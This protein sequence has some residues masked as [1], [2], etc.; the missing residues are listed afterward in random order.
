MSIHF[1]DSEVQ[2]STGNFLTKSIQRDLNSGVSVIY[3][4]TIRG[5]QKHGISR[6]TPNLMVIES[7]DLAYLLT[8]VRD[9]LNTDWE[10]SIYIDHFEYTT[11][12][13]PDNP[14]SE[15]MVTAKYRSLLLVML[16]ILYVNTYITC[17]KL[18]DKPSTPR[19]K[20]SISD[21]NISDFT[22]EICQ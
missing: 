3:I 18:P 22:E 14:L 7:N 11:A 9:L 15:D 1:Y 10:G 5:F 21:Y 6:N 12:C 19:N 16:N 4:D 2:R 13:L 8:L 20:L 17:T